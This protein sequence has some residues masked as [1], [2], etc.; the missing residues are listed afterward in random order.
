MW[1]AAAGWRRAAEDNPPMLRV[2]FDPAHQRADDLPRVEP[3]E[4]VKTVPDPGGKILNLADDQGQLALSLCRLGGS[5]LLLLQ[6]GNARFQPA[7]TR[8]E[9][10]TL[11]HSGDVTVDQATDATLQS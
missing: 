10:V 2:D 7:N 9:F 1:A 6:P 8:L 3:I 11:G 4:T 5:A